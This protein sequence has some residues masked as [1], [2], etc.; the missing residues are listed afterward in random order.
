MDGEAAC[1]GADDLR[2][3]A[4]DTDE[5]WVGRREDLVAQLLLLPGED[6]VTE[7][8]LSRVRD[9]GPELLRPEGPDYLVVIL[10]LSSLVTHVLTSAAQ[11]KH[12]HTRRSTT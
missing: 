4:A 12:T 8:E 1:G 2:G 10:A 7:L 6:P 11:D 9:V 3:D 5:S